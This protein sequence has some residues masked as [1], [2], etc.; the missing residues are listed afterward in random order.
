MY[1][2]SLDSF[3]E[4]LIVWPLDEVI[5]SF[6]SYLTLFLILL[7]EF[8]NMR[9]LCL[10]FSTLKR[11]LL[12]AGMVVTALVL[13]YAVWLY[14]ANAAGAVDAGGGQDPGWGGGGYQPEGGAE[15]EVDPSGWGYAAAPGRGGLNTTRT[16]QNITKLISADGNG[17]VYPLTSIF[18]TR[19][20]SF[21]YL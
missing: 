2:L 11:V 19:K 8:N 4:H 13:A 17:I 9:L 18:S 10:L 7:D 3:F 6:L 12:L 21:N 16:I 1:H 15:Y 5:T 20:S 14:V